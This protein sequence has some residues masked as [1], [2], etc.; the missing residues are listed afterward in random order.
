MDEW[1]SER[2]CALKLLKHKK[3]MLHL[4]NIFPGF[5]LYVSMVYNLVNKNS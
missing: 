3:A 5:I 2:V 1:V 4:L